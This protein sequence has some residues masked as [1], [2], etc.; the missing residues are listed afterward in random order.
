MRP[1][2]W[3]TVN[4]SDRWP[5]DWFH[6]EYYR[7]EVWGMIGRCLAMGM[8]TVETAYKV[9][10]SS[11]A[12]DRYRIRQQ[13]DPNAPKAQKGRVTYNEEVVQKWLAARDQGLTYKEIARIHGGTERYIAKVVRKIKQG[14]H[15]S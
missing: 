12:V 3:N 6:S 10:V 14:E 5:A 11:R 15:T 4:A 13:Q 1:P 9:G 7:D 2:N 8:N